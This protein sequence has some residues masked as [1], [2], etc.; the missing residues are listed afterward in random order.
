MFV[1]WTTA[2]DDPR[3][4]RSFETLST[5]A[6]AAATVDGDPVF[7][8][9]SDD[10]VEEDDAETALQIWHATTGELLRVVPEIGGDSLVVTSLDERPVAVTC[11]WSDTPWLVDLMTGFAQPLPG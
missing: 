9:T 7:V 8:T 3:L 11:G 1:R 5:V 6:V 2:G 4:L 10:M